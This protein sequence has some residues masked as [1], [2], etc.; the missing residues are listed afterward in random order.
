[1]TNT[2]TLQFD[3][4]LLDR[5]CAEIEAAWS[6]DHN[7]KLVDQLAVQHPIYARS[8]YDF[9]ALLVNVEMADEKALGFLSARS[10]LEL[11]V[12]HTSEKPTTVAAKMNMPYPFLLLVQR[13]PE[14]VPPKAREEIA[15]RAASAWGIHRQQ[16]LRVFNQP[17]QQAIAASRD[18][19]YSDAPSFAEMVKRAKMQKK[20]QSFWLSLDS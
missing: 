10:L 2:L 7:D 18:N 5:L 1:M 14:N 17:F 13:H 19:P 15:T 11:L 4:N 12:N 20:E 8:L 16:V 3:R 9:F 6:L